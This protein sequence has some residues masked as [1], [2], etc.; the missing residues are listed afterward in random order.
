MKVLCPVLGRINTKNRDG[1]EIRFGYLLKELAKANY[2]F[3]LVLPPREEKIL[4]H[5][6]VRAKFHQ[7]EDPTA[8]E[9]EN[10]IP[11]LLIYLWR[12]IKAVFFPLPVKP[13]LIYVPG[14]FLVELLPAIFWK[15]K[16]P[17]AK[18]I[19]CLLLLAPSPWRG[20]RYGFQKGFS[21]PN[22]RSWLY[23][24]SQRFGIW[25]MRHWAEKVLVLNRLDKNELERRGL[26]GKV[27]TVDMGVNLAEY[28]KVSITEKHFDA[29]F[30]GRLH[31][32]KGLFDLL[33]IWKI[34]CLSIAGAKL[35]I[36]G[37]GSNKFKGKLKAA[38]HRLGLEKEVDFLD[39][40][41][42]REK[43]SLLKQ[44][45]LFVL[46][47]FYESWGMVA[48]EAMAAGLPVVA[49]KLPILPALFSGGI[50][51]API[52]N[53]D[54]FAQ[55]IALLLSDKEE[56]NRLKEQTSS[57]VKQYDWPAVIGREKRIWE[58]VLKGV[59]KS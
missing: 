8:Y 49:Y 24:V 43:I 19:V 59:S 22:F 13:D 32:Q 6:G 5:A 56:Y 7:L 25:L 29:C 34:V 55:N 42:G 46:S 38:I 58:T 52:G 21:R 33:E 23:Y 35:I 10:I 11:I 28:K 47:S 12:M 3:H 2:Q 48:V 4:R 51:Y 44:S 31:P 54:K 50:I 15:R 20:F 17:Q 41:M 18:M 40:R 30:I 45:R 1:G 16:F 27:E 37:G 14:D 26:R 36:I 9:G 57:Q 39:F 53:K